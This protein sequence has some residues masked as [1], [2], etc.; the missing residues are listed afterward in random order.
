MAALIEA[1][2]AQ[3]KS[4]LVEKVAHTHDRAD[5]Q[6]MIEDCDIILDHLGKWPIRENG[7][8]PRKSVRLADSLKA[9]TSAGK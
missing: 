4:Q 6:E 3:L 1:N 2:I 7:L 9:N 5:W 8:P